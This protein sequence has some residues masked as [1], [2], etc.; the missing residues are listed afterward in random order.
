MELPVG[1]VA[2]VI[3]TVEFESTFSRFFAIYKWARIFDLIEIPTF[4]SEAVLLVIMPFSII[5]ASTGVNKDAITIGFALLPIT[6]ID[7]TITV[8]HLSATIEKPKLGLPLVQGSIRKFQNTN[9]FPGQFS[10][11]SNFPLPFI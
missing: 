2:F 6:K 10:I 5:H 7:I 8:R 3:A 9:A 11:L 4:D 1:E